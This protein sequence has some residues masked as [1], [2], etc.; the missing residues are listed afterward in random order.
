MGLCPC[1]RLDSQRRCSLRSRTQSFGAEVAAARPQPN[2]R[3]ARSLV[4]RPIVLVK[5]TLRQ[6]QHPESLSRPED[7]STER[8]ADSHS[9]QAKSDCRGCRM[10]R[11][12]GSRKRHSIGSADGPTTAMAEPGRPCDGT[13]IAFTMPGLIPPGC[14][15]CP[16]RRIP[17]KRGT[18]RC[19]LL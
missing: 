11:N 19:R 12:L 5:P 8:A 17:T 7:F 6:N 9:P 15:Y 18:A 1:L 2:S 16:I 4:L 14:A 10:T 3:D 13:G